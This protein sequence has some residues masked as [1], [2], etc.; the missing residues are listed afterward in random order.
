MNNIQV[1]SSSIHR[2]C[3]GGV[4][5]DVQCIEYATEK[6][7][8]IEVS[9]IEFPLVIILTQDCDLAQDPTYKTDEQVNDDKRLF[10]VLVAPLY[11][12][13]HVFQGNHLDNLDL[14]MQTIDSKRKKILTNNQTPRYH[15][16]NF[17]DNIPHVPQIIDFKHYFSISLPYLESL[18]KNNFVCQISNLFKED[19]SHRF[20]FYL[21][22]IALP[23]FNENS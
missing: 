14:T 13:E 10:S 11:N 18:K 21:S 8:V 2:I 17:P 22:R 3:Q 4:F 7:G 20:A 23:D 5:K 19:I 12:A 16:I 1:D 6:D 15:Y 9:K